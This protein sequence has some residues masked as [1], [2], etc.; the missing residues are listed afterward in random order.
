MPCI[1]C[2]RWL[3]RRLGDARRDREHVPD[4]IYHGVALGSWVAKMFRYDRREF[5]IA[6]DERTYAVV[7]FPFAPREQFRA[8]FAE[9]VGAL[10]ED[11]EFPASVAAQ[12]CAALHF[13]PLLPIRQP[14]S[15]EVDIALT[16]LDNAQYLCELDL[17]DLGDLRHIQLHVNEY[18]HP[19]GPAP[20]AIEALAEVFAPAAMRKWIK[21]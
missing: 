15:A 11:L 4:R 14:M 3:W 10:L 2:S 1:Q 8:R 19:T 6:L 9:A 12:E 18:P 20:C 16:T 17:Y 13:E 21:H 7:L 5:V